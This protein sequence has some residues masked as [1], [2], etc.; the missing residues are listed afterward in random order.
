MSACKDKL[1][2]VQQH[3]VT[4]SIFEEVI[5][6]YVIKK[7]SAFYK[8]QTFIT[9]LNS[10]LPPTLD[11]LLPIG[12]QSKHSSPFNK[13][14]CPYTLT[15]ILILFSCLRLGLKNGLYSSSFVSSRMRATYA[16][17]LIVLDFTALITLFEEFKS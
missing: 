8:I 14:F 16:T 15:S 3:S 12:V 13:H 2:C 6:S 4:K 5:S 17:H 11:P 10:P 1:L 9:V 7:L